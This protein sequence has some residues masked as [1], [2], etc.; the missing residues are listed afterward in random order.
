[1][2]KDPE[3]EAHKR[4][5]HLRMALMLFL[6]LL[7]IINVVGLFAGAVFYKEF[8]VLNTHARLERFN[9]LEAQLEDGLQTKHWQ[10]ISIYSRFGYLLKGTYLLSPVSSDKTVIFLHGIAANRLMGLWYADMYLDAGYNVLI[11]DSRA[12][13]KSGG[14]SVTWGFYEKNDLDQWVDWVEQLHPNGIIGVHGVSMGAATALEHAKLN[15][16]T[17]RVKFYVADSSYSDLDELLTQ[18][19]GNIVHSSNPFWIKALLKYSSAVAYMQ[20]RFTYDEVSP[21]QAVHNVTTPILY[22]H[23]EFDAVVPVEMST[24]L[25]SATKG[26]RQIHTFS[27]EG[28]AM[29][30]FDRKAEYRKSVQ[31]FLQTALKQQTQ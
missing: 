22:L 14:S 19:I 16:G 1:M 12:H 18:Q 27:Q 21:V 10:D 13:G 11:Y 26:Y 31:D 6:L 24:E 17:K 7:L 28:H 9:P 15:E 20:L 4:R 8:C 3:L 30:I 29:A 5:I 23:G 2:Y 25:F